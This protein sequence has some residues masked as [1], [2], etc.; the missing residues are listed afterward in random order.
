[1]LTYLQILTTKLL[2]ANAKEN[3]HYKLNVSAC[4]L[5]PIGF[6]SSPTSNGKEKWAIMKALQDKVN[7]LLRK[8]SYSSGEVAAGPSFLK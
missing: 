6:C 7:I 2:H 3:L 4:G 1:M 8:S 5:I